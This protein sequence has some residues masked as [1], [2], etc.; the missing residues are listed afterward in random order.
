MGNSNSISQNEFNQQLISSCLWSLRKDEIIKY[1]NDVN[2]IYIGY[3]RLNSDIDM[4]V[5]IKNID[6]PYLYK[7]QSKPYLYKNY[8]AIPYYQDNNAIISEMI[9]KYLQYLLENKNETDKL[10]T[11]IINKLSSK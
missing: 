2:K 3:K 6:I 11:E 5:N 8:Y 10:M 9:S 7:T 4:Y 1:N